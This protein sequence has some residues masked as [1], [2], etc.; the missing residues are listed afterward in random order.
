MA[1]PNLTLEL[2]C[3]RDYV[4]ERYGLPDPQWCA[5]AMDN[6]HH[7]NAFTDTTMHANEH[8]AIVFVKARDDAD[9]RKYDFTHESTHLLNPVPCSEISYLE[10]AAATVISMQRLDYIDPTVLLTRKREEMKLLDNARHLEGY[11]DL[12]CLIKEYAGEFIKTLRGPERRSLSTDIKPNDIT[13]L[14]PGTDAIAQRL[15]RKFCKP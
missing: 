9:I 1:V 13:K 7:N 6:V 5:D 11:N 14:V 10:E 15:C 8:R 4:H 12:M 3:A 2:Q